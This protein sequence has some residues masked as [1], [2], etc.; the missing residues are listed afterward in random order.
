MPFQGPRSWLKPG[1]LRPIQRHDFPPAGPNVVT[2]IDTTIRC[3]N[4]HEVS[5][6]RSTCAA[7]GVDMPTPGR[8]T[9]PEGAPNHPIE[10]ARAGVSKI[11]WAALGLLTAGALAIPFLQDDVVVSDDFSGPEVLRSWPDD[12]NGGGMGYADGSYRMVVTADQG[13]QW[14]YRELPKVMENVQ[15]EVDVEAISGHPAMAASCL[16]RVSEVEDQ[17]GS[18]S[19]ED[20][21]SYTF[22]YDPAAGGSFAIFDL[23]GQ[24]P[25]AEGVLPPGGA[26]RLS[27]SCGTSN[28]GGGTSLSM[29][30][31]D[32]EPVTVTDPEQSEVFR[33]VALGAFSMSGGDEVAFDNFRVTPFEPMEAV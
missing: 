28:E 2:D 23:A 16:Y 19:V 26:G 11:A 13:F 20:R 22:I 32:G 14:A 10:P 9:G 30:L 15:V 1:Y 7:C 4:G 8:E 18:T 33:G 31:D 24:Q 6:W 12:L 29:W 5:P 21:G 17:A 25:L 3:S 27:V